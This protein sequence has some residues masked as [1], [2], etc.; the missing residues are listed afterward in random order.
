MNRQDQQTRVLHDDHFDLARFLR[1]LAVPHPYPARPSRAHARRGTV[2][3]AT[4]PASAVAPA[5]CPSP[6]CAPPART[7][8]S[9]PRPSPT[10]KGA[11]RRC[12]VV[13]LVG[14]ATGA[15]LS[16]QVRRAGDAAG[17]AMDSMG[18]AACGSPLRC[19][20]AAFING[21]G[22]AASLVN[23]WK[24]LRRGDCWGDRMGD[25]SMGKRTAGPAGPWAGTLVACSVTPML[26]GAA[27]SA[28]FAAH[29]WN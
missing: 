14:R 8:L 18:R 1:I 23:Q 12:A 5:R 22:C 3:C 2:S 7:L 17:F 19:A 15:A 29:R 9:L 10:R 24:R 26:D 13:T 6:C 16:S 25:S 20:P 11:M 21:G 4:V 28:G 27:P